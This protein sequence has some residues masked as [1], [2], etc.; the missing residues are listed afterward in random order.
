MEEIFLDDKGKIVS[1]MYKCLIRIYTRRNLKIQMI[2]W[3]EN[4]N[5]NILSL[6]SV[7]GGKVKNFNM[8][9]T[10]RKYN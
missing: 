1:K 7:F 5:E 4:V 8:Y 3:A 6:E 2:R 9:Q 10:K